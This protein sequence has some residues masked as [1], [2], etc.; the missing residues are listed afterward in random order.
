M[1]KYLLT[2]LAVS[3]VSITAVADDYDLNKPFG[4]C[5]VSS[6]TDAT[7]TYSITGGGCYTYPTPEGFTGKVITLKSNGVDMKSTIE[8]AIKQNDVIILDGADGEFIVSS[9]VGI[10]ASKKTILGINNAKIR[11]KWYLTD[12]IKKALDDAGVPSMSTSGGGGTLPNGKSVSEE[13]EYNTRKIIIEMTDDKNESYRNAGI[14]S[15]SGCSNIIIR[16]I[17]FE[18][19]G[20]VDV[21]GADLISCLSGANHCWVDHCTFQDGMDGNFDITQKADFNTVSWC[22]F[23]YT[24]RSYMHQNT[25]LIGSSDSEATG[26]LNTTFAFN[27]W[28]AG[29]RARMPMARVGKIHMLNNYYS[30]AG[31]STA[32]INPRKNSEFLIEGNYFDAGVT[33]VFSQSD[34]TAYRWENSNYIKESVSKPSSSGTV[35]VPYSYTVAATADI[36][37]AVREG[38][39]AT[40]PYGEDI[41]IPDGTTGS[42]YWQTLSNTNAEISA[43]ITEEI[44]STNMTL[45]SELELDG[46]ANISGVGT[47]TKIKQKNVNASSATDNNAITFTLTTKSG[48]KFKATELSFTATRIA[49]DRGKLDIKWIDANGELP[50]DNGVTPAR[51][52]ASTPY[53]TY[54]Y[55]VENGSKATEGTCSFII[56]LYELSFNNGDDQFKDVGFANILIKGAITDAT[57]ITT[58]IVVKGDGNIYNLKGQRVTESYKGI[59]IK[60]GKKMIQK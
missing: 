44:A 12:E 22:I 41:E 19:P 57:G 8:N 29:C 25:N 52:N 36:P 15:L 45:G 7:S 14:L 34:A 40:L 5:T 31:N 43:A 46:T 58:P 59:V 55:N 24:S 4:F 32:C 49:T 26:Y 20:S 33:K 6:R 27:W 53:T 38:A 42:V 51:N 35:T 54:T 37:S 60:N 10:T 13:A 56:N 16:N 1:K 17:T 50:L 23:R 18:G 28:G 21:G 47:E 48:F 39:G 30:C 9:N 11:T 3:L 2:V